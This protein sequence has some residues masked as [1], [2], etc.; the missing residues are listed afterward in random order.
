MNRF[1]GNEGRIALCN[2]RIGVCRIADHQHAHIAAGDGVERLSLR[3]KNLGVFQQQIF[4]LHARAARAGT[5]QHAEITVFECDGGIAG[6]G[7]LVE[8]GKRT[9]VQLHHDA[10]DRRRGRRNF[11]Q[12]QIDWLVGPQ[13][14]PEATRNAS[15]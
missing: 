12:V 13:H 15:A 8:S 14:L 4:A 2:Q 7:H 9:V 1:G 5:H 10:L 6:R 11:Q 3:R